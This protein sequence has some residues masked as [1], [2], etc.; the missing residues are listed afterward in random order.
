M[1]LN[2]LLLGER[3]MQR[4]SR[5]LLWGIF[6]VLKRSF[7]V[8]QGNGKWRGLITNIHLFNIP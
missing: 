3:Y 6:G 2:G 1:T 8:T 4:F 5:L 7:R